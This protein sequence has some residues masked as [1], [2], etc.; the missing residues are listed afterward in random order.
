MQFSPANGF[1][2]LD[3]EA[4]GDYVAGDQM[5]SANL[6]PPMS[7]PQQMDV[8]FN[9]QIQ[10]LSQWQQTGPYSWQV[11]LNGNLLF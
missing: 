8:G 1:S 10:H 2:W 3:L 7:A 9:P 6:L 11:D 4:V 5:A